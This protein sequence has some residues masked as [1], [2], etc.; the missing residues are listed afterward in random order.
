M[1]IIFFLL[2]I[3]IGLAAAFIYGFVWMTKN[4]QYDDL[5]TPAHRMLL[6]DDPLLIPIL[7]YKDGKNEGGQLIPQVIK[8]LG[9]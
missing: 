2:P 5:E 4:G 7:M 1:E 6:E 3:V 8:I 9:K